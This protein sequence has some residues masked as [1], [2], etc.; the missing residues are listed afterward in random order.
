MGRVEVFA[1]Q[2]AQLDWPLRLGLETPDECAIELDVRPVRRDQ[3]ERPVAQTRVVGH[4][5]RVL[6]DVERLAG[7]GGRLVD[8]GPAAVT[9]EAALGDRA[10]VQALAGH[11]FDRVSPDLDYGRQRGLAYE[12]SEKRRVFCPM[13]MLSP[14][15]S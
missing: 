5:R 10:R 4:E 9:F 14:S 7:A 12:S 11:R 6:L 13:A 1:R 2:L 3:V 8:E 15:D